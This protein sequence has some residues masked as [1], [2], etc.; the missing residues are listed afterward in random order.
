MG[1]D[2]CFPPRHRTYGQEGKLNSNRLGANLLISY[3]L[4]RSV[5]SS[6][7]QK[8]PQTNEAKEHKTPPGM[9]EGTHQFRSLCTFLKTTV[10]SNGYARGK[11]D[12]S[13]GSFWIQREDLSSSCRRELRQDRMLFQVSG[14]AWKTH[15][16][17]FRMS[18]QIRH[19]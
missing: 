1:F 18:C 5:R 6:V 17:G 3:R 13:G 16:S 12:F 8:R 14:K 2:D 10:Q 9:A 11:M 4:L 19:R 15:L 7:A